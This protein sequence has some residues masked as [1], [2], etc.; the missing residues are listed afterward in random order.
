MSLLT[1]EFVKCTLYDRRTIEDGY[2]GYMDVYTPGV[3][4]DAAIVLNDSMEALIAQKDGFTNVYTITTSRVFTLH[5]H[6]VFRRDSDG[7][8][9]R[10][11]NDGK[12][13]KTPMGATLDMRQVKAEKWSLPV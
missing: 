1:D 13:K 3:T 11:T 4:F 9:F 10:V 8:I 7:E 6:D 5:Y 12:D 2:G